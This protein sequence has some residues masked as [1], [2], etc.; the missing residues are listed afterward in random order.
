MLDMLA[1]KRDEDSTV[2]GKVLI[3]RELMDFSTPV[4]KG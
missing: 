3:I 2:A 4:G 1:N